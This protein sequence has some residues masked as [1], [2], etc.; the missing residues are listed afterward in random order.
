MKYLSLVIKIFLVVATCLGAFYAV[1][2]KADANEKKVERLR[3]D[4]EEVEEKVYVAKE[5]I[6][7]EE[8]VNVKQTVLLEQMTRTLD[9]LNKKID[10]VTK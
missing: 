5:E 2:N 6:D 1:K 9:N 7:E 10:K 8:K 4:V 3:E